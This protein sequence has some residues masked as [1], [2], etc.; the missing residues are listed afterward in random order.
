MQSRET[1]RDWETLA[2]TNPYFAVI[3]DPKYDVGNLNPDVK[4]EFFRSGSRHVEGVLAIIRT[5]FERDFKPDLALDFGCG[6]GRILLPL[7]SVSTKAVGVDVSETMLHLARQNAR[8]RVVENVELVR[9]NDDLSDVPAG[10]NF[11]NSVIVLQHI[12]PARGYTI[13]AGLLQKLRSPGYFY[14]HLTFAKD[15]RFL[16]HAMSHVDVY[17]TADSE[18]SILQESPAAGE[19]LISMYDYDLN[20]VFLILMQSGIDSML[21]HFTDHSGCYGVVLCGRKQ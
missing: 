9:S 10:Y 11:L 19:G 4:E 18:V 2:K 21:T 17:R 8:E 6:V 20:K 5:H 15:R 3:T 16:H 14:L 13:L 12:P 7:A 1:D